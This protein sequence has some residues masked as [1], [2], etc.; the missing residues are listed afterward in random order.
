MF[1]HLIYGGDYNPEQWNPDVWQEDARLMQ[2]AGVNLVSLGVFAWA[3]M[4]PTPG[5]YDFAWLDQIM[6]YCTRTMS[7]SIWLLRR[8]RHRRGSYDCIPKSCPLR[9]MV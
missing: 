4:E 2:E 6:D 8:R 7:A 5:Q 1:P 9:Q 3:K